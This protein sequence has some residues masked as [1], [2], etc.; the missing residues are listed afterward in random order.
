MLIND[1]LELTMP[2]SRVNCCHGETAEGGTPMEPLLVGRR[3]AAKLLGLSLRSLDHA[4]CRGLLKPRRLGRRVLFIPEEL[5][6]FASR[7]HGRS[8]VA[9]PASHLEPHSSHAHRWR[10]TPCRPIHCPPPRWRR[11]GNCVKAKRRC[12]Q[13]PKK[14][15]DYA[16]CVMSAAAVTKV[17]EAGGVSG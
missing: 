10:L 12:I 13:A 7:D 4:V 5:R 11:P 6:R 16:P 8:S 14:Q 9:P 3:E 15:S 1:I 17:K 2:K